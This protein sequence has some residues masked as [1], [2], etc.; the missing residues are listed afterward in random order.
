MPIHFDL[1]ITADYP[2]RT[3]EFHLLDVQGSQVAFRQTDFKT[4]STGHQQG[5]FDL[6]NFVRLYV[7]E[8]IT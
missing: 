4:I 5:L 2:N 6:R 3:A 7:Q 8:G 1:V